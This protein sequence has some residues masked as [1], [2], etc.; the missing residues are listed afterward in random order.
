MNSKAWTIGKRV[1]T[2]GGILC[3]LL[4]LVGGIA[5][6]SLGAIQG[7]AILIKGDVMPGLIESGGLAAEQ[8]NNFIRVSFYGLAATPEERA[9]WKQ[10]LDAGSKKITAYFDSYETS[11]TTPED[12]AEVSQA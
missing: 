4:V 3:A 2:G 5:W 10:D 9:K 7:N 12:R 11:I 1:T 6:H 8:S